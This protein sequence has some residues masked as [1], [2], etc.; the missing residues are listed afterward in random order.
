[1]GARLRALVFEAVLWASVVAYGS[2]ILLVAPFSQ[3]PT[4]TAM[5][6]HWARSVLRALKWLCGIDYRIRG[7]GS[8]SDLRGVVVVSNHQ[9]AWETLA[10]ATILPVHQTWVMKEELLRIPFFG[11]A[12][13]LFEPIAIKRTD[14][15]RAMKQLLQVGGERLRQGQCVVIFPEGTRV[16]PDARR[17]FG[18]GGALLATS[19]GTEIV[20]IAHNAGH[21]W[22]RR[23]L[24]KRA[25]TIDVVIGPAIE[26][27]GQKA[28]A[29]NSQ[30]EQWIR[31][32]LRSLP[33]PTV[34]PEPTTSAAGRR[35]SGS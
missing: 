30:V 3:R 8:L 6:Q 34:R 23:G 27:D 10:L 26:T 22:P 2:L 18:I 11:W 5:G 24:V 29:I 15:R 16:A 14:G 28:E 7:E 21:F 35:G 25:G 17:R 32:T 9:S 13:R 1:M 12:L 33:A 4:L 31:A 19:T 20:P